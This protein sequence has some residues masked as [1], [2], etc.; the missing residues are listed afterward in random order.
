MAFRYREDLVGKRFLSVSGVSKI[1]VN[2][3]SEWGWKAG[4]I[5]AASHKD[6]KNKELQVLV[7]YDGVDWQRREWV[8]VYSRKTFRV[9]LVERTLVWSPKKLEKEEVKWPALTF[10]PLSADVTLQADAQPVEYLH[11]RQL[12]FLDYANLQPYQDWDAS[13]AG[14]EAGL[15]S[16]TLLALA[17]EAAEWRTTQD[18]QRILTTTPSVLGGCRAQVYRVAGATQWYTAVIVGV[19]EHTGELTV[20]D[21]TVLEEH[22]EDPALVQMRLLGDG[23][24]ESIMRGEVV[25]VMPRRSRSNLQRV[26][27]EATKSP[28]TTGGR[29]KASVRSNGQITTVEPPAQPAGLSPEREPVEIKKG[30]AES[31]SAS[32]DVLEISDENKCV[33]EEVKGEECAN[34]GGEVKSEVSAGADGVGSA[35]ASEEDDCVIVCARDADDRSDSGVSGVRSGGSASS[36]EEWRG[37]AHGYGGGP[38]PPL[39]HL[40]PPPPH[41]LYA[42]E[43]LWKQ[44]YQPPIHPPLH[45][46]IADDYIAAATYDRERHERLLRERRDQEQR[47][48][49][50]KQQKEKER[51]RMERERERE[52]QEREEKERREQENAA[53]KLVSRHFEE[54]LRLA[55]QKRERSMSWSLL[56]S[57]APNR[58]GSGP[59]HDRMRTAERAYYSPPAHPPDRLSQQD[60]ATHASHASHAPHA[61]HSQHAPRHSLAKS[62]KQPQHPVLPKGEPNFAPYNYPPYR[63]EKLKDQH[64]P[65]PPPLVPEKNSV[66]VKHDAKQIHLEQKHP[67]PS[68]PRSEPSPHYLPS[69]PYRTGLSPHAPPHPHPAL[70]T[71]P[72]AAL[73]AQDKSRRLYQPQPQ[74]SPAAY[75]QSPPVKPKVSSPAPPHIYGKPSSNSPGPSP[76][77]HYTVAVEPPM[78][79]TK[80]EPPPVPYPPPSAYSPATRTRPPPVAHSRTPEPRPPPRAHGDLSNSS[81]CQTQ[82][83]DLGVSREDPDRLSPRR[84]CPFDPAETTDVK[85]KRLESPAPEPLIAAAASVGRTPLGSEPAPQAPG[86]PCDVRVPSADGSIETPEKAAGASPAPQITPAA[87]PAPATPVPPVASTPPITPALSTSSSPPAPPA[88]P[89]VMTVADS[90]TPAKMASPNPRDGS[91]PVRHLGKKAWLQRHETAPIGEGDCS[92]GGGTC[93]TLPMTITRVSEPDDSSSNIVV[94]VAAKSIQRGA[95]KTSK[96]RKPKEVNGRVDDAEED[97]T[98]SERESTS[99]PKRKPPK[100]KRKKGTVKKASDESKKKKASESGSESDKESDDKDSDSGGSGSGS[101]STSS[102]RGGGRARGRRSRGGGRGGRRREDPPRR[103]PSA[104]RS[105]ST[106]ESFLQNGPCF[107]VAPRLAKCRECR[108]SPAQRDKDMPNIFCRFYAFR[109]LKY[110]KNRQLAIAGFSDPYKDAEEEDKKLWLSSSADAAELDIEMSCFLLREIGDQFCELLQQEKE[111]ESHHLNEDKTIAWKRVVQG[112]R[113]ICDVC[114]T[115]L[116]NFHWTCGKCGFVVCLDCYKSRTSGESGNSPTDSNNSVN[117]N[118]NGERDSFGWLTCTS[119]GAHPA[120]RLLLTQIAAGGALG[121]AAARAHRARAAFALPTCAC[122]HA[123]DAPE[124]LRTA[125]RLL[126]QKALQKTVKKEDVKEENSATNGSSPVKSENG[127]T[128]SSIVSWLSDIPVKA[129]TKEEKSDT[130]SSD[131]EEGGNFSTLR[132]LLIRP[133]PEGAEAQPKKKQKKNKNDILDD[134]ISSVV[135]E[136][137]DEDGEGKPFALSNV[138]KRYDRSGRGREELPIRIMTM[139]ES[140]LLYPDVPHAW[141][142]DGKLLHLTDPAHAGNYKPFQDQ[143]KRGQPVLVSDVSSLL[144]K[145]LWTPESFSRDFG[146]TRVDLVNCASGLVVPNQ[147]ARKFWDGFDLAAKRLRD[148]RG[149]PMVLKLKDWPPG[150]DFAELLPARFDDLMRVL[151][152]SEYT[153]RNG[154]LNLAARLPECFVRPDLGPKMYTAYGG[155]GGTTNLHLDVS[156]AV[157]VM[158]HASAPADAPE[159]AREAA[160]AAEEAG[161]D[162]LSRR[163]ARVKPPAAL[164]HIYAARDADKIRDFLVRAELERGARPRAQHDPVHDQTWYLDAA[165]RERLYREYGVEGYAILQCPGDAVFVPAGAPHQVRNLLD[166]IKVAEDFVSPENVSRCFELAQQFRRLSRQHANKEDK[167]QIKNIVYHA[168]KDSLC[169]LEEALAETK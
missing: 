32:G 149:A 79:L 117:T 63:Y 47:E 48:M 168:V 124:A 169:C 167:L 101:G 143:W 21:D 125:A 85:R 147:P 14:S 135:E 69:R 45:H 156:D 111:A 100:A 19:N 31:V 152:L 119:G 39:L 127:K 70:Q 28:A 136:K 1:N 96:P 90:E 88:T 148:E 153:S 29:K 104:A 94:P 12:F 78:Q 62:D 2:K 64:L 53:S 68:K 142:C 35:V 116:F 71:S 154:K 65:A 56:N 91:A 13:V 141:L 137:K 122:G 6:N 67:Y 165:L 37:M 93:I 98:S 26:E 97:S 109:R 50:E 99:P 89:P 144:V 123:S 23:V 22:S 115:T 145:D 66:I 17:A 25:G 162:V 113:E 130:S 42:N 158:V 102:K 55:N 4:V 8:A 95:R 132:E 133:A 160:R 157:N 155:A 74:R 114:E 129:E 92:G 118:T 58:G 5:R 77:P 140:K 84:R 34:S 27:R 150:E 49:L 9:F 120:R 161:V 112:V 87:S 7:E 38:P 43:L 75:Y 15:E 59:E 24:I 108:W 103:T 46:A 44:R 131:S 107:E 151:P 76:S 33:K 128:G 106:S 139:T 110:A 146:D 83:L 41:S 3:V 82:P 36:V 121:A 40:P 80:A 134:V 159:R 10:T 81:P 61:P 57:L 72:H 18:G 105:K 54:S 30:V 73:P 138:V 16:A 51:E 20:T 166:C 86:P 163:R 52:K 11:D 60:Y 126:L 164:W